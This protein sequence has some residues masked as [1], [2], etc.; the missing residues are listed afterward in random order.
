MFW[1][2]PAYQKTRQLLLEH[3]YHRIIAISWPVCAH[4][5][6]YLL[7]KNHKSHKTPLIIDIGDP[8]STNALNPP[9]NIVIYRR[10][11][12]R[13]ERKLFQMVA[14][15]SVTSWQMKKLY[16]DTLGV[17]DRKLKV[18]PPLYDPNQ[19]RNIIIGSKINPHLRLVYIGSLRKL[20][21]PPDQ[22]LKLFKDIHHTEEGGNYELHLIGDYS[23]CKDEIDQAR[24]ELHEALIVHG[25]VSHKQALQAT[26][27]ADVLVNIGNICKYQVPSKLVDFIASG[28]PIINIQHVAEDSSIEILRHYQAICNLDFSNQDYSA[29]LAQAIHFLQ[30]LPHKVPH[31]IIEELLKDHTTQEVTQLY[32][33]HWWE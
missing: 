26:Y 20:N 2:L 15:A 10:L 16:C 22:L 5:V 14:G 18:I 12:E 6:G 3:T 7:A 1:I 19:H 8:F 28:N 9:N 24:N 4:V 27:A 21:R 17:E 30:N 11:N 13:F 29:N 25:I 23:E 33:S 31:N 32:L